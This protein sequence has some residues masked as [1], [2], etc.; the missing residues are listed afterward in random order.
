MT[1][2]TMKWD[3]DFSYDYYKKLI[4]FTR[5]H[6]DIRPLKDHI[7]FPPSPSERRIYWRHDVDCSLEKAVSLAKVE[8]DAGIQT[9]YMF[10]PTSLM[11]DVASSK[12]R[13]ALN[14]IM[15]LG[16]EVAVHFDIETSGITPQQTEDFEFLSEA[17]L[18]QIVEF[19]DLLKIKT[20]SVSF[21][22]PLKIF[23]HGPSTIADRVNA[24][25]AELMDFYLSDSRGL[26]RQGEPTKDISDSQHTIGQVLTHPIWWG[27]NHIGAENR[28]EEFYNDMT[29]GL[30]VADKEQF[31]INLKRTL[32]GVIRKGSSKK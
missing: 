18:R 2:G 15:A 29:T 22:R 17:I 23:L 8:K 3:C 5:Q 13:E 27:V 30:A 24:Y 32:S 1:D 25:S 10:I 4:D 6:F 19:E 14:E 28:L 26:W 12:G 9:T 11:Y 20:Y 7:L 31:D 21:H 16:H